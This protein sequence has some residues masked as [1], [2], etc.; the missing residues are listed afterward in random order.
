MHITKI[1][2]PPGTGKTTSLIS[3]LMDEL[4]AGVEPTRIAYLTFSRSASQ[5]AKSRIL[6]QFDGVVKE[7]DLTWFRTI[8]SA[9]FKQLGLGR[10]QLLGASKQEDFSERTGYQL[11]Q[12]HD[13]GELFFSDDDY[14]I[15]L[16]AKALAEATNKSLP[17]VIKTM[18]D[19]QALDRINGFLKAYNVYK[20]D[21]GVY[22]FLDMLTE[23]LDNPI[24]LPVDVVILDEAQ[25]LSKLQW[26]IFRHMIEDAQR[27]YVAGDD[28]Q[29]IYNFIG[30]DP[31]AFNSFP[32]DEVQVLTHSY[33]VPQEIGKRADRIIQRVKDRQPKNV[34]WK[35]APGHVVLGGKTLSWM[36][37]DPNKDT[38]IL[39][40]HRRQVIQASQDLIHIPHSVDRSAISNSRL[41]RVF[42]T[43][44]A[45]QE[46][47]T[48]SAKDASQLMRYLNVKWSVEK[49]KA[50]YALADL[51]MRASIPLWSPIVT[52]N[53]AHRAMFGHLWNYWR[54]G[55]A[56]NVPPKVR[57]MTMHAAKG[58][59]ADEVYIMTDCNEKVFDNANSDVERR[60]MYVALTRAKELAIIMTPST[61]TFMKGF[62]Q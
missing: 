50:E 54:K 22:D 44:M 27:V 33:R 8:H 9:C 21:Q 15:C 32:A 14:T 62:F 59:E 42:A 25:D 61:P 57:I 7:A 55:Y 38:L 43:H 5:E 1:Y 31:V 19:H 36:P 46:G 49:D 28:D 34:Q 39:C 58:Q 35:D 17:E 51:P 48:I 6:T 40:R 24:P 18:G 37:I 30:A 11:R 16:Q 60:L 13:Y 52:P 56:L 53:E 23:Y 26:Q 29:S 3:T 12:D 47:K 10:H 2:G 41:S 45:L 20:K 4:R